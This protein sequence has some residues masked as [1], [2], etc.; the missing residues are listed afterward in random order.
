MTE[1]IIEM[2][3]KTLHTLESKLLMGIIQNIEN[4]ELLEEKSKK[5]EI[6]SIEDYKK[7]YEV[8]K[9]LYTKQKYTSIDIFA[10]NT[11]LETLKIDEQRKES[12]RQIFSLITEINKNENIDF[13]G[14]LEQY[15]LVKIPLRFF[16]KIT[17]NGGLES[18]VDKLTQFHS[19]EDLVTYMEGMI[20]DLTTIGKG[21]T[22]FV[23]TN[24]TKQIT[25]EFKDSL[26]DG[27]KID[28]ID[29]LPDHRYM[30]K[31]LKGIVR[32]VNAIGGFSGTGKSSILVA[33]HLLSILEHSKD[34]ICLFCNEQ[35]YKVFIQTIT[36]AYITNL[37]IYMSENPDPKLISR[38][39][40]SDGFLSD[41]DFNY[42][43]KA[44]E[45]WSE[46]YKDR[47]LHIYFESM[48]PNVLRREIKKKYRQ[49]YKYFVYDTFKADEEE[50][51]DIITLSRVIDNLTKRFDISCIITLQLAGESYGTKYLTYKALARAKAIKEVVEN[52]TLFRR[53]NK[54]E[55]SNL[56]VVSYNQETKK[57]ENVAVNLEKE[58]YYAFFIDKNRN[59]KDNIVLMYEIDLD[60]LYYKEIGII[61]NMPKDYNRK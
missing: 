32:G 12:C 31:Y 21:D 48:H 35:T 39:E 30:N 42:F 51:K 34:R 46:K 56:E 22:N 29:F 41:E 36:F 47:L 52:L 13:N 38:E 59:G 18:F 24:L 43:I 1:S 15:T 14:V 10:L 20:G 6:F 54:E 45:S 23:E 27:N 50:Y 40:Y 58:N 19:S 44:M 7:L 26:R 17:L 5:E 16:E 9:I 57:L 33:L 28:G 55:L 3:N 25:D 8:C 61:T 2:K 4:F 11:F 37:F 49:G 60:Y 53:I